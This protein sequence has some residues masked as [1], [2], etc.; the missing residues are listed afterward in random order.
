MVGVEL[1]PNLQGIL[2]ETLKWVEEVH[3]V[4][5]RGVEALRGKGGSNM[6]GNMGNIVSTTEGSH[7][8]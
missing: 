2:G 1:S 8:E 3:E 4:P 5:T 7:K 6:L